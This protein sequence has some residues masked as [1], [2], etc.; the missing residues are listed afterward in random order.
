MPGSSIREFQLGIPAHKKAKLM[1]SGKRFKYVA[2]ALATAGVAAALGLA[3]LASASASASSPARATG[4]TAGSAWRH[5]HHHHHLPN[6]YE[7]L[8]KVPSFHLTSSTVKNGQPLPLAQ[9]SGIFG[10]PGGKDISPQLS[11]TGFPSQAKSFVVSMFDQEAPT[12]SG[13]WHWVVADIP[14]TST[15]LPEGAGTVGSTL[16]PTGAFPLNADAGTPRFIGGAPPAG[17]GVHDFFITVTALDEASTGVNA[18][19]S[20]ALLGFTIASHTIARATIICPTP[21][22]PAP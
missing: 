13:F 16:L 10:V 20:P 12:G 15:S 8:P 22:A 14:A 9:L 2:S 11:W 7:F 3:S 19:T 6:P 4:H 17:S 5:R 1:V 21:P 18:A